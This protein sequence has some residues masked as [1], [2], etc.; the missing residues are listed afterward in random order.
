MAERLKV[1]FVAGAGRSGSTLLDRLLGSLPGVVPAGELRHAWQLGVIQDEYCGCGQRFRSC[2]TWQAVFQR[3]FGGFNAVPAAAFHRRQ[4]RLL[5][6]RHVPRLASERRLRGQLRTERDQWAATHLRLLDAIAA[7]H[8]A[9]TIVDSSKNPLYGLLLAGLPGIDLR[10]VHLVRDSRAVAYSW[11]RRLKP[12]PLKGGEPTFELARTWQAATW[13]DAANLLSETLP[14]LRRAYLRVR[15][16]DL[17]R[18]PVPALRRITGF[19]GLAPVEPVAGTRATFDLGVHHTAGGNPMR[20]EHGRVA[21][22]P[23]RAWRHEF[24]AGPRRAVTAMTLPLLFRYGYLWPP[25]RRH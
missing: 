3:A 7:V 13:W 8:G 10:V 15:Y 25:R 24:P 11:T 1:V 6:L 5:R 4:E 18:D 14:P 23:D 16:E 2:G 17:A 22:R 21:V 19:A 12:H 20:W 9:H